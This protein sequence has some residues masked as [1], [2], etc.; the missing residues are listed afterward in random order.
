MMLN[1]KAKAKMR[2]Y[3]NVKINLS[4]WMVRALWIA[5][6]ICFLAAPTY[7]HHI[8]CTPHFVSNSNYP[9]PILTLAENVGQ[10]Q[11]QLIHYPGNAAPDQPVD[12][13]FQVTN[14]ADEREFNQPVSV[15]IERQ[16][17]FG[18]GIDIY[19]PQLISPVGNSYELRMEYPQAGNY[20]VLLTLTEGD[21]R[22][23]TGLVLPVVVGQPGQPWVI[24]AVFIIS[25]CVFILVVRAIKVKQNRSKASGA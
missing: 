5:G 14:I 8:I 25:V 4:Q 1:C 16:Q 15:R 13:R 20:L 3:A 21:S 18:S 6:V 12:I 2:C 11:V 22:T 10:W 17:A 7:A 23:P 24:L 19:G 9:E